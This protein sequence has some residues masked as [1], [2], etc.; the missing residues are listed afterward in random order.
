MKKI[1]IAIDGY[2]AC[3]KSSTAKMIANRLQYK[4]IDS[5]AMYRAVTLYFIDNYVDLTNEKKVDKAL[6]NIHIDFRFN[7]K[8]EKSETYLNGLNVEDDIRTMRV[9]NMVSEVSALPEVRKVLVDLQQKLGKKKGV[10]M[11]GRDIGSVVLPD[12]ELKVFMTA[13]MKVRA[14][15]RQQELLEKDQL[16]DLNDI[17]DNLAKRDKIDTTREVGPLTKVDDAVEIDTTHMTLEEQVEEIL[18]EATSR[19]V[20]NKQKI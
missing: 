5:G 20:D 10:V 16:V 4:Y 9:T 15:R 3:G 12:A 2:S 6:K 8:K 1:N 18:H 11:D 7:S 19:I 13:D 17:I 14:L